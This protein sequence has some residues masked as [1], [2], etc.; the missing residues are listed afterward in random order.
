MGDEKWD[1]KISFA[2]YVFGWLVSA[3]IL[4][5]STG[6]YKADYCIEIGK[7]IGIV[8]RYAINNN[9]S[10]EYDIYYLILSSASTF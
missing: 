7:D 9:Q 1:R 10:Y 4:I 6:F 3:E 8:Y 2:C 5:N